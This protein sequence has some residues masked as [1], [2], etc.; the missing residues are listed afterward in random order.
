MYI[1]AGVPFGA[2]N[3][4]MQIR[5][6]AAV[7]LWCCAFFVSPWLSRKQSLSDDV[8]V[9]DALWAIWEVQRERSSQ[10]LLVV[11]TILSYICN[12]GIW[13][14]GIRHSVCSGR[15]GL[16]Y[17]QSALCVF[18]LFVGALTRMT[19]STN[20]LYAEPLWVSYMGA[21][22]VPD[23]E[24]WIVSRISVSI[25]VIQEIV[26]TST[27][28]G[29]VTAAGCLGA[30][31][32]FNAITYIT[33]TRQASTSSLALSVVTGAAMGLCVERMAGVPVGVRVTSS[34]EH[35]ENEN[36]DDTR[37]T[38]KFVISDQPDRDSSSQ[39]DED[40]MWSNNEDAEDSKHEH[41][42]LFDSSDA[43][44]DRQ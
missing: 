11:W 44:E 8:C 31:Y 12:V 5:W 17:R 20:T 2:Y 40:D 25:M 30:L 42:I 7:A 22:T 24:H 29:P 43:M 26:Y 35:S 41:V 36:D 3:D 33:F 21:F 37:E 18:S 19:G 38:P 28:T 16:L 1:L 13:L 4:A 9:T 14:W 6:V 34:S 15:V 23:S 32:L 39:S 10:R 27:S